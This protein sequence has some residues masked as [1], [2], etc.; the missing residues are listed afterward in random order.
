MFMTSSTTTLRSNTTSHELLAPPTFFSMRIKMD[1]Q[2]SAAGPASLLKSVISISYNL[3]VTL[4]TTSRSFRALLPWMERKICL[5]QESE[6]QFKF[7]SSVDECVCRGRTV[8]LEVVIVYHLQIWSFMDFWNTRKI[9]IAYP[10]LYPW[11]YIW[12]IHSWIWNCWI[13]GNVLLVFIIWKTLLTG[14]CKAI[15]NLCLLYHFSLKWL[16]AKY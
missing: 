9:P 10:V 11:K 15:L 12:K 8:C 7:S 2:V 4:I 13:T 3:N 1:I 14:Y 5:Q 16:E 6:D